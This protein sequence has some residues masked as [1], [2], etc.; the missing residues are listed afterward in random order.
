MEVVVGQLQIWIWHQIHIWVVPFDLNLG[1]SH[2]LVP[3][4]S[5]PRWIWGMST[6]D[7]DPAPDPYLGC[8]FW[9]EFRVHSGSDSSAIYVSPFLGCTFWPEFSLCWYY[10][11]PLLSSKFNIL[12]HNTIPNGQIW[13]NSFTNRGCLFADDHFE[14]NNSVLSWK[15]N[16]FCPIF[17]FISILFALCLHKPYILLLKCN[18]G[19]IEW[20]FGTYCFYVDLETSSKINLICVPTQYYWSIPFSRVNS[21]FCNFCSCVCRIY[22]SVELIIH[23]CNYY[24]LRFVLPYENQ[25][26]SQFL[27]GQLWIWI[28]FQI[29]IWAV[30]FDLN[31]RSTLALSLVLSMSY[32]N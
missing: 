7:P 20:Q 18:F 27:G 30:L 22:V 10:V 1:S 26:W 24:H 28:Q 6:L 31:L 8:T 9:P 19:S 14:Y 13:K 29:H 32:L 4:M 21:I 11:N 23:F 12:S 16:T 3:Y 2:A 5:H 17:L 15:L 25:I